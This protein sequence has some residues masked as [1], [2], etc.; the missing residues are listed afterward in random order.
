MQ[1][2][3]TN[4]VLNLV[5]R[6]GVL[7]PRDL[8]A[9]GIPREYL[10]RLHRRGLVFRAGRGLYVDV[11]ADLTANHTLAEV[12]KRVPDGVVCLLSALQFHGFTMQMPYQAWLAISRTMREPNEPALPIRTVRM[13]GRSFTAGVERHNIEGVKAKIYSPAKTV[14]DCFKFRNKI[15]LDV[16]LEALRDCLREGKCSHDELWRYAKICRQTNV[17]KPYLESIS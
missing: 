7:R 13:T 2:T 16:A 5:R 12:C 17:M 3:M 9:Y 10:A 11:N 14:V 6:K 1:A 8:D 4:K 15:G